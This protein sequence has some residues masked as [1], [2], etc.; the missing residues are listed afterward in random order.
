MLTYRVHDDTTCFLSATYFA[1]VVHASTHK[2]TTKPSPNHRLT[3]SHLPNLS[4]SGK[5]IPDLRICISPAYPSSLPVSTH[6]TNRIYKPIILGL[7]TAWLASAFWLSALVLGNGSLALQS[8]QE[9]DVGRF[10][11]PV[12]A[13]ATSN[14][15]TAGWFHGLLADPTPGWSH[16]LFAAPGERKFFDRLYW[17][18]ITAFGDAL[19]YAALFAFQS[20]ARFFA[21]EIVEGDFFAREDIVGEVIA[22]WVLAR[23]VIA[24]WV[25]AQLVLVGGGIIVRWVILGGEIFLRGPWVIYGVCFLAGVIA[26]ETVGGRIWLLGNEVRPWHLD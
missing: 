11:G 2:I 22:R 23:W 6:H 9:A 13:N 7:S 15:T 20:L 21:W 19:F 3:S 5:F 12:P 17:V 8:F 10:F 14:S 26:T 18:S 16:G 1:T 4:G 25:I 24:R